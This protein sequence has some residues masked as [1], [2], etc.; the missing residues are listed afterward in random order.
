MYADTRGIIEQIPIIG[1]E[2]PKWNLDKLF[3]LLQ[4]SI[5]KVGEYCRRHN[6]GDI[7][8]TFSGGLDSSFCLAMLCQLF[9]DAI[10]FTHTIAGGPENP[11]LKF[12]L[13]T[14]RMFPN[15]RSVSI[16]PDSWSIGR[17]LKTLEDANKFGDDPVTQADP[18]VLIL[19]EHIR[20]IFEPHPSSVIVHDG[21]DELLGGYWEHRANGASAEAFR[22]FWNELMPRH[23]IPLWCKAQHSHIFPL[24]AYID[25]DLVE[26]ISR[27]PI[28]D[29]TSH[30]ESKIPLRRLAMKHFPVLKEVIERPKRG[31]CDAWRKD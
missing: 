30:T 19:Y 16:I 18:L 3:E 25:D 8:I 31:F 4:S 1:K 23:L 20:Y 9:P 6:N 17:A 22:K 5:K 11:D 28:R 27:I 2:N 12:A 14:S 15:A 7:H 13:Q 10:I 26:Y 24:F 29:R 21:I